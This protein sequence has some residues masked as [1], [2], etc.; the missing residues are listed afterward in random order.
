MGGWCFGVG[1]GVAGGSVGV[2]GLR[3]FAVGIVMRR[4]FLGLRRC[5][6][7]RRIACS[8]PRS[9]GRGILGF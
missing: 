5:L 4:L 3:G 6:R 1:V 7:R 8:V 9:F 2:E